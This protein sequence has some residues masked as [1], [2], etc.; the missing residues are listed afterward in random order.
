M[1]YIRTRTFVHEP[2]ELGYDNLKT[3]EG[4]AR[5]YITPE[6]DKFPSVTTILGLKTKGDIQAWRDRVGAAEADR[7]TRHACVRGNALHSLAEKYLNNED[8]VIEESAMPHVKLSF[9]VV[10]KVLDK[11][12]GKIVLQ[13][14]PLYSRR[15]R[16]AGRVD[17]VAE[18]DGCLS[19]VDFKTSSRVKTE[20][21]IEN[22]FMQASFYAA[23][24]Y[25]R[26]GIAIKQ[27]VIIMIVDGQTKPLV[28]IQNSYKWLPALMVVRE[29][30]R[31][32]ELFGGK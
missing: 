14:C 19:I 30:Y 10:Q 13:E 27:I 3:I 11:H 5:L 9:S 4:K 24:F 28:F 32:H 2:V 22:Y 18:F 8:E 1:S 15:L 20:E 7:I 21:D 23:A 17:L 16:L 6:G 31:K 29:E 25:E 12:I 26:T